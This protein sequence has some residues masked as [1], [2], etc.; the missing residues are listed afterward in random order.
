M[1]IVS[2]YILLNSVR[3]K[4]F[5]GVLPQ[6]RKVG[7]EYSVSLRVGYDIS[8][9][10]ITDNVADTLNYAALYDIVRKQMSLPSSLLEHV[11]GRIANSITEQFPQVESISLTIVKLNPP[12]GADSQ[13]AGI[14]INWTNGT[15]HLIY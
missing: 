7:G 13:G 14:E 15:G 2:S 10:I 8:K 1:K 3:L 9:A 5:H 4:A 11:A 12:T 6:E